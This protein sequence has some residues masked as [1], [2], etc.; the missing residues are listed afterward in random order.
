L[1]FVGILVAGLKHYVS[2]KPVNSSCNS[3]LQES[4]ELSPILQEILVLTLETSSH[5]CSWIPMDGST[6]G[7]LTSGQNTQPKVVPFPVSF[8]KILCEYT[9]V[10]ASGPVVRS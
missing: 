6:V 3:G 7:V 5:F 2:N 1:V 10:E 9:L 4:R 8:V